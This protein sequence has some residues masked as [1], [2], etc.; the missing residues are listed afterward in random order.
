MMQWLKSR[1]SLTPERM[2]WGYRIA[3]I[4]FAAVLVTD[5]L[6]SAHTWL[7]AFHAF[8]FGATF[9]GMSN[10]RLLQS[11]RQQLDV[12]KDMQHTMDVQQQ[13]IAQQQDLLRRIAGDDVPPIVPDERRLN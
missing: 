6:F 4:L 8:M 10:A 3:S 2:L 7:I 9:V 1:L 11:M 13:M 5:Y 12:M